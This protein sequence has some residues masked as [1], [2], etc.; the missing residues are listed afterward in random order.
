MKYDPDEF[1][2]LFGA[3]EQQGGA[4]LP[5]ACTPQDVTYTK[6]QYA[7][8]SVYEAGTCGCRNKSMFVSPYD[9]GP[10][11]TSPGAGFVTACAVCDAMGA[12]PRYA[13]ALAGEA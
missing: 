6:P 9:K 7:V 5:D 4:L 8:A 12:W 2:A 10:E 11:T 1:N 3:V 13:P